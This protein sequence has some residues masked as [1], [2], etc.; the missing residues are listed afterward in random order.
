[1]GFFKKTTKIAP[2]GILHCMLAQIKFGNVLGVNAISLQF[3]C[4]GNT[5]PTKTKKIRMCNTNNF[6]C[7]FHV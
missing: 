1:M 6:S 3:L 7:L 5:T 4:G 2:K